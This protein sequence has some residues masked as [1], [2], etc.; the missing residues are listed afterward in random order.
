[1]HWYLAYPFSNWYLEEMMRERGVEVDHFQ[2]LPLGPKVHAAVGGILSGRQE[3][4]GVQE[5]ADG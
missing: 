4:P 5:L 1:M 3:T 2:H